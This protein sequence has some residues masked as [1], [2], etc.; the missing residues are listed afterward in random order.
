MSTMQCCSGL[1]VARPITVHEARGSIPTVD[2]C[3]YHYNHYDIQ[4]WA[5][6]AYTVPKLTQPSILLETVK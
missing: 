5:W 3:V 4:P 6:A 1:V 2:S